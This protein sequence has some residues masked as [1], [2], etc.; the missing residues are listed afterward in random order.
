MTAILD[1]PIYDQIRSTSGPTKH[2]SACDADHVIEAFSFK[3]KAKGTLHSQCR[4]AIRIKGRARYHEDGGAHREAVAARRR[5]TRTEVSQLIDGWCSGRACE[6]C[7]SRTRLCAL[8][9]TGRS[10]KQMHKD[11]WGLPT[12]RAALET[13]MVMC[14]RC[15]QSS[16]HRAVPQRF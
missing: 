15:Q 16:R 4:T 6:A 14:T 10:L 9:A 2:C 1:D 8:A 12:I 7:G 13:A 11:G 3:N 5:V